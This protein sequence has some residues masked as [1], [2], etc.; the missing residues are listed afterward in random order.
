MTKEP[1]RPLRPSFRASFETIG[2]RRLRRF[3]VRNTLGLRLFKRPLECW[4]V[5]RRKRRA[6]VKH[7]VSEQSPSPIG[8][9]RASRA[10]VL[11]NAATPFHHPSSIIQSLFVFLTLFLLGCRSTPPSPPPR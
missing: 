11:P 8:W 4:T 1:V 7:S 3:I 5:K 2:A 9:V 10:T 6:P